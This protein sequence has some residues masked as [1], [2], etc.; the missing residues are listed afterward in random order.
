MCSAFRVAL[1]SHGVSSLRRLWAEALF[2]RIN[3]L[4]LQHLKVKMETWA[5]TK[6]SRFL[7]S[8]IRGRMAIHFHIC[9]WIGFTL[10]FLGG[11]CS[12]AFFAIAFSV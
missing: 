4:E 6:P 12:S 5:L 2:K 1:S 3:W 9:V 10:F 8:H 7:F 11:S